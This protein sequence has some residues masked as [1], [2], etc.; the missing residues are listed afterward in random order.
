MAD[1]SPSLKPLPA[2]WQRIDKVIIV[3]AAIFALQAVLDPAQ[4]LP[5][6]EKAIGAFLHTLPFILFAVAAVAYLKATDAEGLLSRAFTGNVGR[7]IVLGALAGGLSPFCSCEVIPFIAALLAMGA[8]LAA[9]MAFWLSSPLM[10]PAMFAV[11]TG[12]LGLDFAIAKTISAVGIGLLGGLVIL[13]LSKTEYLATPLKTQP[14]K[15]CGSCCGGDQP[16]SGK[17]VWA[18][19]KEQP[20][21]QVFAQVSGE[22]LWFLGK[23]LMLAYVLEA[24][25]ITY[26]PADL[27]GQVLGGDG[28]MPIILGALVGGPA[29]MN[30]YAAVP[31]IGG[32]MEQG[33]SPGAA[34]SFVIAGGVS[35]VPAAVAVWALVK[36]RI[37]VIY[38]GLGMAGA[39]LAGLAWS[40]YS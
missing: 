38:L 33:M 3:I 22:Q 20:R 25:M 11:T 37:F 12:A 31:V 17:P 40:A 7:M 35:C 28:V 19:W 2:L 5:N 29:Y 4:L 24:L 8:P 14:K 34:M 30:G 36:P 15:S 23:W 9:V 6:L 10:D 32:L 16:F 39:V 21:R 1:I 26:V 18:F 27:I 13:A